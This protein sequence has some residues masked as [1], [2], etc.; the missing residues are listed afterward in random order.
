MHK[1]PTRARQMPVMT[2]MAHVKM[3]KRAAPISA[4]DAMVDG[5]HWIS[6]IV[7]LILSMDVCWLIW[8]PIEEKTVF[9][10]QNSGLF[11]S[12]FLNILIWGRKW[13]KFWV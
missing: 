9:L 10:G 2:K 12:Q 6:L 5:V 7:D 4:A 8:F 3:G 11:T 13:S 1:K